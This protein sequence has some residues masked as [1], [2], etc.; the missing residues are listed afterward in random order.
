MESVTVVVPTRNRRDL[1]RLTLTSVFRQR[2]VD[3]HVIVVDDASTDGSANA[4]AASGDN[5]LT[6]VRQAAVT[7][8]SGARNAG[9]SRATTEWVA[10][11]DDDDLWSPDKLW[12]QLEAARAARADWAYTGCVYVNTDLVVQNGAPPLSPDAMT[13]A[14]RRYNAMPAGAS[15]VA[16]R[17]AILERLGGFDPSLTHVPDWDLW[18][19]LARHGKPA[20]VE[21]PL[22]GYR[23]HGGNASF[24]TAEMLAE[25]FVFERRHGVVTDRSRFHRHLAH[26]SLRAGRRFA[27]LS[28]FVRAAA[29]VQDGYSRVDVMTDARLLRE[30]VFDVVR[31]RLGPLESNRAAERL[32]AERERDPNA[33]WKARAQEWLDELPR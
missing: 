16:V 25:L 6:V 32:R 18:L 17:A 27:A 30:H 19:R 8:V 14:L 24:R 5:R 10:F 20:C 11:C 28:H 12:R 23:L 7:G 33:A 1:L 13:A 26:L 15:N 2:A 3:L 9:W 31:R 4:V 21:D 22:V 29:R